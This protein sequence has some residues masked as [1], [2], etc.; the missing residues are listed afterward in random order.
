MWEANDSIICISE[1]L[2]RD[3]DEVLFL[4]MDQASRDFIQ[5]RMNGLLG[6]DATEHDLIRQRLPF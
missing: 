4:V 5:P 6:K 1:Q 3:I 2:N